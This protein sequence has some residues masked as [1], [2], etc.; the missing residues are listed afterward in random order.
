M[1][2]IT[3]AQAPS[4]GSDER[5]RLQRLS[6]AAFVAEAH[7]LS[8]GRPHLFPT[9]EHAYR[10]MRLVIEPQPWDVGREAHSGVLWEVAIFGGVPLVMEQPSSQSF[11]I[12]WQKLCDTFAAI[13]P[14]RLIDMYA[15]TIPDT[16][17]VLS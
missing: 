11:D 14:P 15:D 7:A 12:A 3:S 8:R 10:H 2:F 1:Y 5:Q 13:Y 16:R 17:E 9:P 4:R 6:L